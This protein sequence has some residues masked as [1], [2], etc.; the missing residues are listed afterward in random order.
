[1]LDDKTLGEQAYMFILIYLI[2]S[3]ILCAFM[4]SIYQCEFVCFDVVSDV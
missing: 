1:M 2:Y 4:M 3:Y